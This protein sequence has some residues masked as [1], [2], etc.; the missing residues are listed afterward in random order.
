[1]F[2]SAIALSPSS[3]FEICPSEGSR[4]DYHSHLQAISCNSC[5]TPVGDVRWAWRT[6]S[7]GFAKLTP[8]RRPCCAART[9]HCQAFFQRR[10]WIPRNN[11]LGLPCVLC[12]L[13][14]NA[15]SWHPVFCAAKRALCNSRFPQVLSARKCCPR[16][17][18][19]HCRLLHWLMARRRA[20]R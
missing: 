2:S 11:L 17:W 4:G 5:T 18:Q 9:Q 7:H 20:A 12:A 3:R 1:M 16:R 10:I 14:S 19:R 8:Q 6:H 15:D 13:L